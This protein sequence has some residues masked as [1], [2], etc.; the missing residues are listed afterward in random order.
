MKNI[1]VEETWREVLVTRK[2]MAGFLD[3]ALVVK[4]RNQLNNLGD[5]LGNPCEKWQGS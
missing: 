2:N 3:S 1:K 5:F 4:A